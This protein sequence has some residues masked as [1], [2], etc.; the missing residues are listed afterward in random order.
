MKDNYSPLPNNF[1]NPS[2]IISSSSNTAKIIKYQPKVPIE[3]I[4]SSQLQPLPPLS[5]TI[6]IQNPSSIPRISSESESFPA[7]EIKYSKFPFILPS[8]FSI[9]SNK[10]SLSEKQKITKLKDSS[11]FPSK[12]PR[13]LISVFLLAISPTVRD[14]KICEETKNPEKMRLRSDY[15]RKNVLEGIIRFYQ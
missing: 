15:P 12:F 7:P 2:S 11:D 3:A 13:I 6:L 14:Q 8:P 5:S 4:K 10:I 1:S 9:P